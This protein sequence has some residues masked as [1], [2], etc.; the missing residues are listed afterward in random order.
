MAERGW[1]AYLLALALLDALVVLIG[2][3]VGTAACES[4]AGGGCPPPFAAG[5]GPLVP[6]ALALAMLVAF[7][8]RGAYT[9][10]NLLGGPDEYAAVVGA[11]AY[12]AL[13]LVTA[14]YLA[15]RGEAVP[16]TWF[17]TFWPATAVLAVVGRFAL[18]RAAYAFR[19]RGYLQRRLL[20]VGANDQGLAIAR[21]LAAG[22]HGIRLMGFLDDFLPLGTE[23]PIAPGRWLR[24]LGHSREAGDL[25]RARHADM[26][27]VVPGA[28]G[29]ESQQNMLALIEQERSRPFEVRFAPTAFDLTGVRFIPAP[30]IYVPLLRLRPHRIFGW[31]AVLRACVD[32]PI[33]LSCVLALA[34]AALALAATAWIRGDRPLFERRVLLGEQDR[35]VSIRLLRVAGDR[36]LL[37]GWP[38]LFS[39]LRGDLALVGPRPI[40]LEE[41]PAFARWRRLL[42][43]VRPGLTGPWRL[44][45]PQVSS[46]ERVFADVWWVRNW[47]I[48]RHVFVL[49]QTARAL[50]M[51]VRGG[52]LG[53]WRPAGGEDRP[54]MKPLARG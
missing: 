48:W 41:A 39:V 12:A 25:A 13:A 29:W 24:V 45:S 54:A 4:L 21:Q 22:A 34:P 51:D 46:E 53:R 17:L 3:R 35:P 31:D 28:L 23:I 5:S 42:T 18:R 11:C 2:F 33:A 44:V 40:A 7:A 20:I 9:R 1:A 50:A 10:R 49:I 16:Q 36:L 32:Y 8:L 15:G 38:V 27:V 6:I 19:A 14:S 37:R 30:L 52:A 43:S 26:L 47:T